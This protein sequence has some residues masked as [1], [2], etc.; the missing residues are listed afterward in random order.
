MYYRRDSHDDRNSAPA[1]S[2]NHSLTHLEA[3][4]AVSAPKLRNSVAL[5]VNQLTFLNPRHHVAQARTNRLY[6]M[7]L[8]LLSQLAKSFAARA[9][10]CHPLTGEFAGLY[11]VKD[12]FHFGLN[13]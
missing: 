2:S 8:A 1:L 13:L 10:L 3:A 9:A 5:L 11:F 6:L 7:S 4:A 12:D